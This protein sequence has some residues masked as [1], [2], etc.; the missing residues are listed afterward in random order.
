MAH[1]VAQGT[2]EV[3]HHIPGRLRVRVPPAVR[4]TD[5]SDA[6]AAL[7]GVTSVSWSPRTRG[8]LVLY[9]RERADESAIVSALAQHAQV[10]VTR[11]THPGANGQRPTL[12][13]TVAS[14]FGE[15]NTRVARTTGGA[16]GLG[17]LVPA[18]LTLWA[19]RELL[20]GRAAPLA[21][22][23]ALWYAHGL[24]RDYALPSRED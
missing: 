7:P 14:L 24:F 5:L 4:A 15:V 8:L 1:D 19:A 13:A 20:R 21:W 17:V 22:S 12:A 2:L 3:V 11:P 10:E 16:L 18:V 6:A 9:D 23:S